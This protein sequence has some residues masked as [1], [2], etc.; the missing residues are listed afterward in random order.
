M[1]T[2]AKN[3]LLLYTG[4]TAR[5]FLLGI[6]LWVLVARS[7]EQV[8][9]SLRLKEP[10]SKLAIA[11][12]SLEAVQSSVLVAATLE[13]IARLLRLEVVRTSSLLDLMER[14]LELVTLFFVLFSFR[15]NLPPTSPADF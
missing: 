13:R 15:I 14:A 10:T 4:E 1:I 7:F 9:H 8:T 3:L 12:S 11:F 6:P 5:M 2:S